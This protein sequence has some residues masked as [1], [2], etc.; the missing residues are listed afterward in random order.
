M[1]NMKKLT[2]AALALTMLLGGTPIWAQTDDS[3]TST[4]VDKSPTITDLKQN[5]PYG[6]GTTVVDADGMETTTLLFKKDVSEKMYEELQ[7][8]NAVRDIIEK[9]GFDVPKD[10]NV[11]L[12]GA[13]DYE[14]YVQK[15]PANRPVGVG[16]TSAEKVDLPE[17]G[18]D[19]EFNVWPQYQ[20]LWKG[21]KA[22]DTIYV[23]HQLKNGAWEVM[24]ATLEETEGEA[25]IGT[26]KGLK[27][28]LHLDSLSPIAF[29]KVM[30]DGTVVK[31]D[32]EEVEKPADSL[33]G[34]TKPTSAK[35][36]VSV[37]K[38]PNTGF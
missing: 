38:S 4:D 28:K 1:G 5:T 15:L 2:G 3:S 18:M 16:S 9:A 14:S 35:K 22:G 8:P 7:K 26:Q 23:M 24:E 12:L 20:E 32:K 13:G 30:S 11:V 19:F 31:L 27:F 17:G 10:A 29:V 37:K 21:L 36:L 34:S 33:A 6:T 25:A